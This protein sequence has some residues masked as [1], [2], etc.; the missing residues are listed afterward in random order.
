D[1][2]MT[3]KVNGTEVDFSNIGNLNGLLN[4]GTG[5]VNTLD[6]GFSVPPSPTERLWLRYNGASPGSFNGITLHNGDFLKVFGI[7]GVFLGNNVSLSATLAGNDIFKYTVA[8]GGA[9]GTNADWT[10][11]DGTSQYAGYKSRGGGGYPPTSNFL[12]YALFAN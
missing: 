5:S 1:N 7:G 9:G 12:A 8:N 10:D 2:A 11:P 6:V 4:T 3:F